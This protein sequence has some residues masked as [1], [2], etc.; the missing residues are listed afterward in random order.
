L[1]SIDYEKIVDA[2]CEVKGI[3]SNELSKILR[4]KEC[5]YIFFLLL[6][7]YKCEDIESVYKNFLISN[8]RAVNYGSKKAEE[9]FF[10]N[11]EFREIF[12]EIENILGEVD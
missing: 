6:K 12:F 9:R 2:I 11:K 3:K 8:K 10:I 5:K 7:K 1:K 4:D